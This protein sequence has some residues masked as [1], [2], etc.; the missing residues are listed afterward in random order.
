L[1]IYYKCH[2]KIRAYGTTLGSLQ[3]PLSLENANSCSFTMLG[4]EFLT[5]SVSPIILFGVLH[6]PPPQLSLSASMELDLET[7]GLLE[8][9][10]LLTGIFEQHTPL[11]WGQKDDI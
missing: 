9:A 1:I 11:E 5:A 6:G 2:L 4:H 10:V 7:L 3:F 8:A